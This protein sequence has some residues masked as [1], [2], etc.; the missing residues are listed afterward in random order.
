[1]R[2]TRSFPISMKQLAIATTLT[3]EALCSCSVRALPRLTSSAP[4]RDPQRP[5]APD[6]ASCAVSG[7]TP[8]TATRSMA[9][10]GV[11]DDDG[12][13][14]S[15]RLHRRGLSRPMPRRPHLPDAVGAAHVDRG[16]ARRDRRARALDG[17]GYADNRSPCDEARE[18]PRAGA[19]CAGARQRHAPLPRTSTSAEVRIAGRF[20]RI[21]A[22]GFNVS[23][24]LL[25]GRPTRH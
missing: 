18:L 16:R 5:G 23:E 4:R 19:T 11:V 14:C 22:S 8:T 6:A 15:H 25:D 21:S 2:L 3:A 13:E 7:P 1:M 10:V 20:A 12:P 24:G 9:C 17:G